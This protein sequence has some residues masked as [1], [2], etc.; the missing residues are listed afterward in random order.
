[1]LRL[2]ARAAQAA[3]PNAEPPLCLKWCSN[4]LGGRMRRGCRLR[5]G[6]IGNGRMQLVGACP[7]W[8]GPVA[9]H[10]YIHQ[11]P[12]CSEVR[13]QTF[14]MRVSD[15]FKQKKAGAPSASKSAPKAPAAA[16]A[17]PA[18]NTEDF[19]GLSSGKLQYWAAGR[20]CRAGRTQRAACCGRCCRRPPLLLLL[21]C[22]APIAVDLS[23]D[24]RLLREF[25]LTRCGL[26]AVGVPGIPGGCITLVLCW[27]GGCPSRLCRVAARSP[28]KLAQP[29]APPALRSKFG[30][31]MGMT[32]L[33]RCGAPQWAAAD[34]GRGGLQGGP[35]R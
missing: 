13:E 35:R 14:T 8:E 31:C 12:P 23:D 3:P 16:K 32:R 15:F 19:T 33:E 2:G 30:P 6:G 34:R 10:A 5:C 9:T 4:T 24:E 18:A 25:D 27:L 17:A 1:M 20:G 22:P 26:A 28:L 7:H 11:L 29:A 21:T